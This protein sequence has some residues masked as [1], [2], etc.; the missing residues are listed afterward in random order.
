MIEIKNLQNVCVKPKSLR[1]V[2]PLQVFW[3]R[4]LSAKE[5]EEYMSEGSL[6]ISARF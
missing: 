6:S 1:K 4:T 3:H 2:E 5:N